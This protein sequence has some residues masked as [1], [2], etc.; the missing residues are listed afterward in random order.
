[1]KNDCST[2]LMNAESSALADVSPDQIIS[3]QSWSSASGPKFDVVGCS[4]IHRNISTGPPD[5]C[6]NL[7]Y[8]IEVGPVAASEVPRTAAPTTEKIVRARRTG[9]GHFGSLLYWLAAFFVIACPVAAAGQPDSQLGSKLV[10]VGAIGPAEQGSSVALSADGNTAI[11]GGIVDNKLTGAAW[12]YT[13]SGNFWTQQGSKLVGAGTVGQAGQGVS[14]ALS[15]DGNT[16]IVGGPYDDRGTGAAWVYTRSGVVW[17]QQGNKLLGTGRVGQARQG[18][19]VALS[20][21]GNTAIVGGAGDNSYTGAAWVY[22]R[23]GTV[24]TQQGSKLVGAGAVGSPGQGVSVALSADGNT[25]IVGGA[26]DDLS[27]GAAWV[28]TRSG[29]VWAQQGRKL[30]GTGAIGS[31]G[32]GFSVALSADGNTAIVGGIVDNK[33]TGAAW[34]YTRSGTVWTQQ[35]TKLVGAETLGP[36]R[37]GHSVALSADGNTAVV[38]GPYD[39]SYNGAAWVYARGGL[40]WTQQGR[41]LVGN[42]GVATAMY[43]FS[44]ALSADGNTAIAGA[45]A[46]NRVTGAAWV[47]NRSGGLGRDVAG[48]LSS[49]TGAALP[50][51]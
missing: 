43:G 18:S 37:Q 33:L 29:D 1:M 12:V 22:S 27:T 10:G 34:I 50:G 51:K 24:W 36:A 48:I 47:Y 38:G 40:V 19:S 49:T 7:A 20:A 28:Y 15:A 6:P 31:A 14:V 41:K 25:A 26:A 42:S 21:D 46:D 11:V 9:R 32:Q 35:G 44:V 45:P 30:V 16:V 17:S 4:F 23:S 2:A 13:R 39:N 5:R 3:E 8:Q